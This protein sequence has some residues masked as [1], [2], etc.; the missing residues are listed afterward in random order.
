LGVKSLDFND[1]K[2]VANLMYNKE[3][4]TPKGLNLIIEIVNGMN[5]DR[6]LY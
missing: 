6:K 3:H 1:F 2:L 4:L 5:L